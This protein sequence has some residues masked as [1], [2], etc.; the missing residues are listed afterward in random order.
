M[1][2]FNFYIARAIVIAAALIQSALALPASALEP[3]SL[4]APQP[5]VA[6]YALDSQGAPVVVNWE[7][8]SDAKAVIVALHGFGLHK[9]AFEGFAQAMRAQ[10]VAVYALDVRG[11][12]GWREASRKTRLSFRSALG[13]IAE[14]LDVVRACHPNKPVYLLGESMGGALSLAFAARHPLAVDGVIASVPANDRYAGLRTSLSLA[15]QAL[16]NAG[17]SVS[18]DRV[19]VSRATS[20][21]SVRAAWR[22]DEHARLRVSIRELLRFARFMRDG[23]RNA[24]AIEQ[25]PVL[26]LQGARDH[27]VKP[28]GTR[29]IF[30]ALA[31]R[32]KQLLLLDNEE[33]LIFEE[34]QFDRPVVSQVNQW[35]DRHNTQ[36]VVASV[37]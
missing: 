34:G 16:F 22:N 20:N 26:I 23:E 25:T 17:A 14:T 36:T 15:V 1:M 30:E 19:L 28:S 13:D 9:C 5:C 32:D 2:R 35:I 18:L 21:E 7:T 12:G 4:K 33:H 29:R 24:R 31:T 3:V 10:G 27:L 8:A 37:E 6:A 11:F